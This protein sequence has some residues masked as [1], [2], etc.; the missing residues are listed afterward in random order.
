[1]GALQSDPRRELA[2]VGAAE[3]YPLAGPAQAVPLLH[4]PDEKCGVGQCLLG[5]EPTQV[6]RR[7]IVAGRETLAVVPVLDRE[8]QGV[9]TAPRMYMY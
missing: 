7:E 4:R 9:V 2:R 3:R 6:R 8:A 5:A 1:M